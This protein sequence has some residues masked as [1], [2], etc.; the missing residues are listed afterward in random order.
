MNLIECVDV[1]K[2]LIFI[3]KHVR[4]FKG[5]EKIFL[6]K[7]NPWQVGKNYLKKS[8]NWHFKTT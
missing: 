3:I 6:G 8:S 1:L 2:H 4:I 7:E 5:G